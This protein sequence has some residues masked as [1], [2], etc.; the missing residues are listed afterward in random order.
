MGFIP[1]IDQIRGKCERTEVR[2]HRRNENRILARKNISF[3]W[4]VYFKNLSGTNLIRNTARQYGGE[5]ITTA[6]FRSV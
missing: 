6:M 1:E 4:E 5:G 2:Q 3:F